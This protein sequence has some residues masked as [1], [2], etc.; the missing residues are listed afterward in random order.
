MC[1]YYPFILINMQ[2]LLI[3]PIVILLFIEA[4][5]LQSLYSFR[6]LNFRDNHIF[7]VYFISLITYIISLYNFI[8]NNL[9]FI[10]YIFFSWGV[11]NYP[12]IIF[13]E[14]QF[15]QA[16]FLIFFSIFQFTIFCLSCFTSICF[17]YSKSFF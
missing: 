12:I 13:I 16:R 9:N 17:F 3:V 15:C 2:N 6:I 7:L 10:V 8:N 14:I 11:K 5:F 1:T 4:K